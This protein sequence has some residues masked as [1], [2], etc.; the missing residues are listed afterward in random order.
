MKPDTVDIVFGLKSENMKL[1]KTILAISFLCYSKFFTVQGSEK[2]ILDSLRK[3]SD[4]VMSKPSFLPKKMMKSAHS[5][6]VIT[7]SKKAIIFFLDKGDLILDCFL[8]SSY[9]KKSN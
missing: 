9:D 7:A 2:S 1:S 3:D 5:A 6:K 4:V 8:V